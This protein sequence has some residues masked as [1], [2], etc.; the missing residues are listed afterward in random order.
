MIRRLHSFQTIH[1]IVSI[2]INKIE[3]WLK[4][5][6]KK[7]VRQKQMENTLVQLTEI[8]LS[9]SGGYL[10][11]FDRNNHWP[12]RFLYEHVIEWW[13]FIDV[14]VS[15]KKSLIEDIESIQLACSVQ[16]RQFFVI[17]IDQQLRDKIDRIFSFTS[18]PLQQE[19]ND[20]IPSGF[21]FNVM[22]N[23]KMKNGACLVWNL[24]LQLTAVTICLSIIHRTDISSKDRERRNHLCTRVHINV[25]EWEEEKDT[26]PPSHPFDWILNQDYWQTE[27]VINC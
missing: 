5:L 11:N 20:I 12:L 15:G 26:L 14:E 19:K 2:T 16:S 4:Y 9:I 24:N 22:L 23:E 27:I 10:Y 13:S 8:D 1:S 21:D 7:K 6:I 3:N 18:F 25:N 17:L